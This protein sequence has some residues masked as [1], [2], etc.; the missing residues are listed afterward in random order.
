MTVKDRRGHLAYLGGAM[1]NEAIRL[2]KNNE[3]LFTSNPG[4]KKKERKQINWF[5]KYKF[6]FQNKILLI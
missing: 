4:S 2:A 5:Q 1:K 3:V 6:M